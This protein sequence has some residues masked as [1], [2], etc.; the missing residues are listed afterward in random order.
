MDIT[1]LVIVFFYEGKSTHNPHQR[2]LYV[3]EGGM[4]EMRK[5]VLENPLGN[6]IRSGRF[7]PLFDL[8]WA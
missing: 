4:M 6:F 8:S 5:E 1:I 7:S 2:E 3:V